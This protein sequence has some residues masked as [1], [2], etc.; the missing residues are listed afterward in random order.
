MTIRS[1]ACDH[2]AV[3]LSSSE[4]SRRLAAVTWMLK[5]AGGRCNLDCGYCYARR[6]HEPR[7]SSATLEAFFAAV[8]PIAGE[9]VSICWQGGEPT[10]MGVEWFREMLAI[11]RRHERRGQCVL[12]SIQTNATLIDEEW[13]RF[14]ATERFLVGASI[15][16]SA[17]AHDRYRVGASGGSYDAA[18][19]G[20]NRLGRRRIPYNVLTVVTDANVKEPQRTWDALTSLGARWLQ[21]IP[22]V[23]WDPAHPGQPASF[24]VEPEAYGDFLC[25]LFDL[26]FERRQQ[27][28]VRLFDS[29]IRTL[30]YGS[31][32]QCT[33][34]SRCSAQLT[35]AADG[36]VYPCDHFMVDAWQL[37]SVQEHGDWLAALDWERFDA[38]AARKEPQA[39]ACEDCDYLR[40]CHGGCPKHRP[41]EDAVSH[42]CQSTRMWLEHG[43]PDLEALAAT[44]RRRTLVGRR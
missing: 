21:M 6:D 43:L 44:I 14:V 37:G 8:L 10:L 19:A 40:F 28:S 31:A 9:D 38:F 2:R 13:A 1:A 26:W 42:V 22:A 39:P 32:S 34:A 25:E 11:Q 16:G 27:I 29:A 4:V 12:S 17:V 18:V 3:P 36:R 24:V 23:E 35:V 7:M 30:V 33:Q 15:D 5:P 41:A 20:V